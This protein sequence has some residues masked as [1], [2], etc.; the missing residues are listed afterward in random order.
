MKESD[1]NIENLIEKMMEETTL[2]SPSI[3][4]TS[5]IMSQIL[6]T[7]KAKIKPY[8]PL[9]SISTWIFIGITL[10][11]LVLYNVFFAETQNNLEIGKSYTDKISALVSGIHVSKTLLYALL[12]VPFMILIQIGILKN[13]FDKKYQL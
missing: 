2:Q 4:F 3:D 1:K 7:E 10:A 8:K 11:I 12:I 6:V 13:Y 9:I 5:S